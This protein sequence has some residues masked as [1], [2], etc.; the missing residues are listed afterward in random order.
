MD[1]DAAPKEPTLQFAARL[2]WGLLGPLALFFLAA[3]ILRDG[4]PPLSMPS[5]LYFGVLVLTIL[6]RLFDIEFL[7]GT[8]L[9]GRTATFD[10]WKSYA[11]LAAFTATLAWGAVQVIVWSERQVGEQPV[12]LRE[13]PW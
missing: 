1:E 6:L 11:L 10:S 12:E 5:L 8:T 2:S 9:S 3:Y 13:P 7:G 4:H